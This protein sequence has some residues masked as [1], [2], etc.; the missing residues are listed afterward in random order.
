MT[1]SISALKRELAAIKKEAKKL[2]RKP[3]EKSG[4]DSLSKAQLIEIVR[5]FI[6]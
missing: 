3:K 6:N 2:S 1:K 4:L 5:K